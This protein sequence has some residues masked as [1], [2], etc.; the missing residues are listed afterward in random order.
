M[1]VFVLNLL[2]F[3]LT[4]YRLFGL[5]YITQNN[6]YRIFFSIENISLLNLFTFRAFPVRHECN[7]LAY[8]QRHGKR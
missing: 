4:A 8:N 2:T 7:L 3:S 6:G 5:P 1:N